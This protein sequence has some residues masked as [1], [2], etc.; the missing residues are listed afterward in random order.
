MAEAIQVQYG[1]PRLTDEFWSKARF[2]MEDRSGCWIWRDRFSKTGTPMHGA[3]VA[4][5]FAYERLIEPLPKGSTGKR[6]CDL[7]ECV[8][9]A[10]RLVTPPADCPTCHRPMPEPKTRIEASK[11]ADGAIQ[12]LRV[13]VDEAGDE[14]A[15]PDPDHTRLPKYRSGPRTLDREGNTVES[16]LPT[17]P[18]LPARGGERKLTRAE[19]LEGLRIQ[20]NP[21]P[22]GEPTGRWQP[23]YTPSGLGSRKIEFAGGRLRL[24]EELS[25]EQK[26]AF[27]RM[28][29]KQ[30]L[31]PGTFEREIEEAM[32]EFD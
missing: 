23:A 5:R 32:G 13:T 14:V 29:G 25:A 24:W 31:A 17:L 26:S 9:P 28:R 6:V 19:A 30:K 3:K 10:H 1:D 11:L 4:W 15:A 20:S 12:L 18:H 16:A 21:L 8:N 27:S 22:L 2:L 7:T